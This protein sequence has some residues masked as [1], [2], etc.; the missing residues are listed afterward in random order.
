MMDSN[1]S[2]GAIVVAAGSSTRMSGIDKTF[3][4]ILEKPMITYCLDTLESFTAITQIVLVVAKGS[5]TKGQD[6]LKKKTYKKLTAVCSGGDRRQDSVRIGLTNINNCSYVLVHDGARPCLDISIL[7]RGWDNVKRHGA[8]VAGVPVKDTI[9]VA[10]LEGEVQQTPPRESLWAAQT[11][12]FFKYD[13]LQQAHR[14]YNDTFTD[15]SSMVEMMGHPVRM[16]LGSYENLKI[17]TI[18]DL[19]IAESW[20]SKKF[21]V[22]I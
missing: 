22:N 20:I 16:F 1:L 18:E 6:I 3:N 19:S 2:L 17:T 5:L 10:S 7:D 11:P 8:A 14:L 12:Q 13:L 15:D 4:P 21:D 9:K